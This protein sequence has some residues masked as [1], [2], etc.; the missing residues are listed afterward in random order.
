MKL[1]F[2]NS[3]KTGEPSTSMPVVE[4]DEPA[5][6]GALVL[7]VIVVIEYVSMADKEWI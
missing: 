2:A 5:A 4:L 6:S 7:S 3:L 1:L